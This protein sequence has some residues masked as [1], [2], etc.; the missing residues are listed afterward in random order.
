MGVM[1]VTN[2][3]PN[4]LVMLRTIDWKIATEVSEERPASTFSVQVAYDYSDHEY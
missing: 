1:V 3:L 4:L 2:G